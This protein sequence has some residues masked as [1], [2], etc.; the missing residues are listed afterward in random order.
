MQKHNCQ[1]VFYK[2][3]VLLPALRLPIL[4]M[5]ISQKHTTLLMLNIRLMKII[6]RYMHKQKDATEIKYTILGNRSIMQI[7]ILLKGIQLNT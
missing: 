1:A 3:T 5:T 4:F 6:I 7:N 2:E